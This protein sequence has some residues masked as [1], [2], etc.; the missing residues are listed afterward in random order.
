VFRPDEQG[1]IPCLLFWHEKKST[2][3]T[4][5]CLPCIA[6]NDIVFLGVCHMFKKWTC[7]KSAWIHDLRKKRGRA[8]VRE[9]AIILA[10]LTA[11]HT[12]TLRFSNGI[13]WIN[14]V[15]S[16]KHCP[17]FSEFTY[18]PHLKSQRQTKRE[19]QPPLPW[20]S[21]LLHYLCRR[22]CRCKDSGFVACRADVGK[23][24]RGEVEPKIFVQM[25][26]D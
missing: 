23:H 11:H 16:A 18:Q 8:V 7:K 14:M 20:N 12:P 4:Q 26:P 2:N 5:N 19:G 9:E 15:F 17:L 24:C 21:A 10:A 1:Q 3:S 13:L 22:I 25:P 6:N